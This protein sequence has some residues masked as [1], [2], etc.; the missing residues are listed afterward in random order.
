VVERELKDKA[1]A[2]Q[3]F[4]AERDAAV[5]QLLELRTAITCA[6]AQVPPSTRRSIERAIA[7]AGGQLRGTPDPEVAA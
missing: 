5:R 7:N 3:A 6:L 2:I 4:R 1:R